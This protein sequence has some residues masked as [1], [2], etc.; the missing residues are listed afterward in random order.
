MSVRR[1]VHC[2]LSLLALT[3]RIRARELKRYYM[4]PR[5]LARKSVYVVRHP[6][7]FLPYAKRAL[8]LVHK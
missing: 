5:L 7:A 3:E 1:W 6:K 8:S 2:L 4:Q